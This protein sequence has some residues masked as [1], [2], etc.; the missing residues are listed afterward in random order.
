MNR[1]PVNIIKYRRIA[2]TNI[3]SA[4]RLFCLPPI[5]PIIS[6]M[7]IPVR[8][9]VEYKFK[10]GTKESKPCLVIN[11]INEDKDFNKRSFLDMVF[12]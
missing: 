9:V 2:V 11:N 4:Y 3:L 12:F 5:R 8:T 1:D 6:D 10:L 7:K